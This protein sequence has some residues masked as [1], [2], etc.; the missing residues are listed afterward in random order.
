MNDTCINCKY[1][2][3][4]LSECRFESPYFREGEYSTFPLVKRDSWCGQFKKSIR[5]NFDFVAGDILKNSFGT[6]D[7]FVRFRGWENDNQ[8]NVE[9]LLNLLDP[10]D[11]INQY[12]YPVEPT[13]EGYFFN[14]VNPHLFTKTTKETLE[15]KRTEHRKSI[16]ESTKKTNK[17]K[18]P[19]TT[20][21]SNLFN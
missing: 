9:I 10:D 6:G 15:S 20:W 3:E 4:N 7:L 12:H 14:S 17:K 13:A 19:I 5:K 8:I 18:N 1:H 11:R 2:E 21:L 16:I